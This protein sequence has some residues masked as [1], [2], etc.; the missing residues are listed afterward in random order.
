MCEEAASGHC[1]LCEENDLVLAS[2]YLVG[3]KSSSQ[4]KEITVDTRIDSDEA[5]PLRML[6]A[7]L[8]TAATT[9]PPTACKHTSVS[10]KR[11]KIHK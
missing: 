2:V 7:Y 9:N 6:S 10:V 11:Y 8:I 5:N 3:T 1:S 4:K